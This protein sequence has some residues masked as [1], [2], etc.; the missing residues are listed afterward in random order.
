MAIARTFADLKDYEINGNK[1]M[2]ALGTMNIAGSMTSCYVAT[3]STLITS[4][5]SSS[6][7]SSVKSL[8]SF[9]HCHLCRIILPVGRELHGWLQHTDVEHRH[10]MCRSLDLRAHHTPFQV[11]P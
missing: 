11:Y 10:G 4:S 5:S 2:M 7:S 6:S 3:G 1:E 8:T 9:F